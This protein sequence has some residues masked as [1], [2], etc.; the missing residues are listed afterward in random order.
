[1]NTVQILCPRC[2][3]APTPTPA[4]QDMQ[5]DTGDNTISEHD[6]DTLHAA[7]TTHDAGTTRAMDVTDDGGFVDANVTDTTGALGSYTADADAD[8][9]DAMDA[10]V[11]E[12]LVQ[13]IEATVNADQGH[14]SRV[15]SSAPPLSKTLQ[16]LT[17]PPNPPI[18]D[19]S[20]GNTTGS[21]AQVIIDSFPHGI[22][23]TPMP[24]PFQGQS[25][26]WSHEDVLHTSVWAP[27][28][29]QCDWEIVLWAKMRGPT[30]SALIELLQI[31]EV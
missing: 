13:E 28:H 6:I 24:N 16:P 7:H 10:D 3:K 30:L 8:T 17:P 27:F 18:H 5:G 31:P 9:A 26:Y 25:D 4:P 29:S 1:M 20:D 15:Q 14:A 2:K 22:P 11:W 23:G 12:A 19:N 21:R